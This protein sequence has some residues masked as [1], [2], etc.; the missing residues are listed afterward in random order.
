MR[1][2]ICLFLVLPACAAHNVRCDGRLKPINLPQAP[3]VAGV[4]ASSAT[5]RVSPRSMP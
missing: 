2:I 5:N 1:M 4:A 3:A